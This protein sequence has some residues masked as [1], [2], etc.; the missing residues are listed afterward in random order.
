MSVLVDTVCS[1]AYERGIPADAL[2][3]LIDV[4]TLEN[5]LDQGSRTTVIK[6][7]YPDNRVPSD[8]V[9][10]VV[11]ALGPSKGKPSAATQGL[12]VKWLILVY[13]VLVDS[14]VLSKLYGVLF[15]LLD[16]I[17]LRFVQSA[18]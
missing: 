17:S 8:V 2:S 13:E 6:N 15:N 4:V 1:H 11:G 10:R 16:M 5:H 9:F 18:L 12:L 7:L 14:S 3:T